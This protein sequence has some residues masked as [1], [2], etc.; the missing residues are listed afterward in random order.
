MPRVGKTSST[1]LFMDC[2]AGQ[3]WVMIGSLQ[4]ARNSSFDV[5]PKCVLLKNEFLE[6]LMHFFSSCLHTISLS[7]LSSSCYFTSMLIICLE[8]CLGNSLKLSS[9]RESP[10]LCV[11]VKS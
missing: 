7:C 3:V 1:F 2:N 10:L 9:L 4:K 11:C 8:L 6:L 5:F